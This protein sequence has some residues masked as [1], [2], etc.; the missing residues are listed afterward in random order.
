MQ[1]IYI[2]KIIAQKRKEK[3]V[4]QEALA[5]YIGVTKASVSK[6]ETNQSYPDIAILPK[7]AAFFNISTDDLLGYEPQ[8]SRKEIANTY[9][10]LSNDALSK[11]FDVVLDKCKEIVNRYYSC[12]P[13]LFQIGMFLLNHS[14]SLPDLMQRETML[15]YTKDLFIRVKMDSD[16][17]NLARQAQIMEA[18]CYLFT[19][20]PDKVIVTLEDTLDAF[21]VPIEPLMAAAYQI[22][23][24]TDKAKSLIQ[25]C[26]YQTVAIQMST[27]GNYLM[28]VI[29]DEKRFEE[30]ILRAIKIG[31]T[32]DLEHLHPALLLNFYATIAPCYM[33]KGDKEN[34]LVY[35]DK[36]GDLLAKTD[37][38]EMKSDWYFDMLD[39]W[40]DSLD[41]N[42]QLP[43]NTSATKQNVIKLIEN[44][45]FE[46]LKDEPEYKS[47]VE[48]LG[49]MEG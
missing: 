35:L 3:S 36:L 30:T 26:L 15:E 13:L 41:L 37:T 5:N 12:Y 24:N 8:M 38:L 40:F 14:N 25:S 29:D 11:P 42:K 10:E 9:R 16:N 19:Q 23:G 6:W 21:I 33:Q 18:G 46:P 45:V 31:E 2:G 43:M 27:L 7:L 17:P 20:Q 34:A 1:D 44:P 39:E 22:K 4:T 32:Y 28:L 47:I 49:K 48:K